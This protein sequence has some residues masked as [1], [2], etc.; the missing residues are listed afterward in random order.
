[1]QEDYQISP[2]RRIIEDIAI[3]SLILLSI[4]AF[5]AAI[6]HF[7]GME[8]FV[9]GTLELN[10]TIQVLLAVALIFVSWRVYI[11]RRIAWISSVLVLLLSI[12]LNFSSLHHPLHIVMLVWEVMALLVLFICQKDFCRIPSRGQVKKL[13]PDQK[14]KVREIVCKYGQNAGSYLTLED[15]KTIYFGKSV[16][17]IIPYGIVG[18]VIVING[19]P[20]CAPENFE[21]LLTEF[22][23]Y[24]RTNIYSSVFLSVTDE[25]LPVYRKMGY[26][27]VKCGEEPRFNVQEY[28]LKGGKAAKVRAEVNHATKEGIVVKEYRP[29]KQQMPEIEREF[30]RITDEWLEGK[31]SGELSFTLGNVGFDEPM[32]KRYFYAETAEGHMVGFIVF[33]PFGG[34]TGYM[35]DV[36]RRAK[37]A[38]RGVMELIMYHSFLTFKEEGIQWASMGLAP[39]ARMDEGE[40]KDELA[41]KLLSYVYEH[42]NGFY[43]FKDLYRAK[44]KYNPTIWVPGYFAFDPKVITPDIAYAVVAIQNPR[45][46]ADYL[47]GF[48]HNHKK[49]PVSSERTKKNH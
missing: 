5:I 35:A 28:S 24:C 4:C 15:D 7:T 10:H 27:I 32:D 46:A 30:Q 29:I 12:I 9:Y 45:G 13:S 23:S 6:F 11:R 34:M 47:K 25:F 17:G 22:R 41:S 19:D 49:M 21:A 16:E 39:L 37:D 36:T 40:D 43:G 1:M 26:G 48:F 3:A 42:L 20:I 2:K 33:V 14:E 44:L 38:P 8:T 31:K 18:D